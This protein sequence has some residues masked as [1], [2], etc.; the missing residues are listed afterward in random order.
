MD[1]GSTVRDR[2][3]GLKD[4]GPQDLIELVRSTLNDAHHADRRV[5]VFLFGE[6]TEAKRNVTGGRRS[7]GRG[8]TQEYEVVYCTRPMQTLLLH[9][10]QS[11]PSEYGRL[12]RGR[13]KAARAERGSGGAGTQPSLAG[14][15]SPHAQTKH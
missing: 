11:R 8:P 3:G 1:G 9:L 7:A 5:R 6:Q 10:A 15:C 2:I 4:Q 12:R 14:L 13:A